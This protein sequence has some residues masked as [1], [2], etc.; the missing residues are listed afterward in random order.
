MVFLIIEYREKREKDFFCCVYSERKI[1]HISWLTCIW[2]F[3]MNQSS[4][5]FLLSMVRCSHKP[6]F[7]M[8]R[9]CLGTIYEIFF[10]QKKTF[11][12]SIFEGQIWPKSHQLLFTTK[13]VL[14]SH[15]IWPQAPDVVIFSCNEK[16]Y[17]LPTCI[18]LHVKIFFFMT[19]KSNI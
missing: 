3:Y 2:M 5:Y 14:W 10:N 18:S 7:F 11:E 17:P 15:F 8:R 1:D 4:V 6:L 12:I 19:R 9:F 16:I 13:A